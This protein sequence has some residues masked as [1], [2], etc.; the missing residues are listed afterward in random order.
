MLTFKLSI[1]MGK[2]GDLFNTSW[3][4]VLDRLIQWDFH[5]IV[6]TLRESRAHLPTFHSSILD[7]FGCVHVYDMNFG[8]IMCYIR[9]CYF[10]HLSYCK[11]KTHHLQERDTLKL[12]STKDSPL[13]PFQTAFFYLTSIKAVVN[14]Q[15]KFSKN[16]NNACLVNI[17]VAVKILEEQVNKRKRGRRKQTCFT[18]P[19]LMIT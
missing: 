15:P 10:Q 17:N 11:S 19:V 1:K 12:L 18:P 8:K 6:L 3:L 14:W 2:K 7:H 4:L 16:F 13:K 5:T 9:S